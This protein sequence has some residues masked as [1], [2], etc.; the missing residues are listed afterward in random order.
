MGVLVFCADERDIDFSLFRYGDTLPISDTTASGT[1]GVTA[2]Y[3]EK[4][5]QLLA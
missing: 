4:N 2:L 3:H 5:H 1:D